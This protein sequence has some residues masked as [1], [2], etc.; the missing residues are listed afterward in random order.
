MDVLEREILYALLK[1]NRLQWKDLVK[2]ISSKQSKNVDESSIKVYITRKLTS[3]VDAGLLK[4]DPVSHKQV[5]YYIPEDSRQ[6][7]MDTLWK[8][9]ADGLR[10]IECLAE[11]FQSLQN[12]LREWEQ[13]EKT[14]SETR[15]G[16]AQ[17]NG[18]FQHTLW[19]ERTKE[20]E[21]FQPVKTGLRALHRLYVTQYYSEKQH[22]DPNNY[23]TVIA[24]EDVSH[25]LKNLNDPF[26]R[27]TRSH[28]YEE[29]L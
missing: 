3:F 17:F 16:K 2:T 25:P 20:E 23:V 27:A 29:S 7:V 10:T 12:R 26:F 18:T 9:V 15:L 21:R 13:A 1:T 22:V 28:L 5:F 4:K 24:G 19:D 14:K 6:K 8:D 11:T